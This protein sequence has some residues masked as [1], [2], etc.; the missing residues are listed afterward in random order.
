MIKKV[1]KDCLASA[2]SGN[3]KDSNTLKFSQCFC[4]CLVVVDM[5]FV[6]L[7]IDLVVAM[8]FATQHIAQVCQY[9]TSHE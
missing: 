6:I 1:Q 8:L 3:M 5:I 7:D 9:I 2:L 4:G